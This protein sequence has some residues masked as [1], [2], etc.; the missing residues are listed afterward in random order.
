MDFM[1]IKTRS[2]GFTLV[3]IIVT[4]VAMGILGAIFI[5]FMGTALNSSWNAVEIA[6]DEAGAEALMEQI[7]G[8]YVADI[9]SDPTNALGNIATNYGGQTINGITVTT[10]YITFDD[11]SGDEQTG[12]S[13]Y[14][15][16]VL[17]ASGLG[18]PAITGRYPLVTILAW[19]RETDLST[20][21]DEDDHF[22]LF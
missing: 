20:N 4:I 18:P 8:E 14:L 13:D 2:K 7:I 10:Q 1:T 17:Q 9:N 3:E 12:G 22:V 6:R 19:N 15:K 16:V 5:N 11:V 21:E